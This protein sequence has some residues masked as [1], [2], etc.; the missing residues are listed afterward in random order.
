MP[1]T[2]KVAKHDAN[3]LRRQGTDA[4][5]AEQVLAQVW[6][7]SDA[8]CKEM[9]QSS[10]DPKPEFTATKN[11]FVYSTI[12]AYN[13]HYNLVIRPEDIWLAILSQLN[14]YVNAHA[15]ELRTKFVA[16][17]GKKTLTVTAVGTRYTV[18]FGKLAESL[19]DQ[20]RQN[21]VDPS[22]HEWIIPAY[23]TT[24]PNDVVICSV[25]MMS[26]LKAY[27][28]YKMMLMC[29]LPSVTLLGEKHDYESIL[30]K[31]DKL[32]EFGVEPAAF[33]RLLRPILMQFVL[34]FDVTAKGGIPDGEFW[35]KICHVHSGGSGPS[36]L[37]GWISSF[38]VFDKDG[39]WQGPKLDKISEPL[40]AEESSPD[41]FDPPTPLVYEGLRY[42]VIDTSNIPQGFC[43]VDVKLDDNGQEFDCMMVAG[44]VGYVASGTSALDTLQPAAEWFIFVKGDA[45]A[46]RHP[47]FE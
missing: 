35:G 30:Q 36:Y 39:K 26:T 42:P 37:S 15:E 31:L 41:E 16:H 2:F 6:R 5:S 20:L 12:R 23:T 19:G 25:M 28:S 4:M 1:I 18:N 10:L 45:P 38:C 14:L 7:S 24:T 8:G 29:G 44:H 13:E 27:F 32:E 40:S 46:R 34:A 3:P 43:E 9:L 22:L 33:A 11:G 17:E 21:V 47:M